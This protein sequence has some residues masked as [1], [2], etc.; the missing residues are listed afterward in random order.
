MGKVFPN[1][2]GLDSHNLAVLSRAS[3]EKVVFCLL[4][5]VDLFPSGS[6]VLG[7]TTSVYKC[8]VV[9]R[10]AIQYTRALMNSTIP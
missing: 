7:P 1:V 3:G 5:R 10:G 6:E 4:V 9:S 8:I 2:R